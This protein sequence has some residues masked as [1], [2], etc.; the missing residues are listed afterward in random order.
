M[1]GRIGFAYGQAPNA[2]VREEMATLTKEL[3]QHLADFNNLI[4]TDVA[5]YN[6]EAYAA[7]APTLYGG[8]PISVKKPAGM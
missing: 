5:A 4:K 1:A 3:D 6:K 2:L 8:E 7:G